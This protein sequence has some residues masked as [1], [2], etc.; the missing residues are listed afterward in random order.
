MQLE[1]AIRQNKPF[2]NEKHKLAVNIIY[3][4][5]WLNLKM[6]AL[7][8]GYDVTL[9]QFNVLRILRGQHP[10]PATINIIIERMLDKMSNASRL[11]DK[12]YNKGYVNRVKNKADRRAVDVTINKRGLD[13]L[14]EMDLK[15]NMLEHDV[16][17]LTESEANQLNTLMDKMRGVE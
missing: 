11:V 8:K 9:Q 3:T 14:A 10:N 6:E 1:K 17:Q 13:F 7:F 16:F 12:L 4:Q 5:S 15:M 2:K